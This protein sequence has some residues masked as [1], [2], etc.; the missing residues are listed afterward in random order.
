MSN[1]INSVE[2]SPPVPGEVVNTSCGPIQGKRE[3]GIHTFLGIPFAAPPLGDLRWKPPQPAS[4]WTETRECFEFGPACP[5]RESKFIKT[6]EKDEDC[7][8]LNVWTP[9]PDP[10]AKLPVMF[11]LQGGNFQTGSAALRLYNGKNMA[12]SGAVMVTINYRVGPLGFLAHPELSE[13]SAE[14]VSGNYGLLDQVAALEWVRDN[15]EAFGGDPSLVTIFGFSSGAN[16]VCN[17]M[18]MEE[19]FSLYSRAI[20]QSGPLWSHIGIPGLPSICLE[21][22]KGEEIGTKFQHSLGFD[23]AKNVIGKMREIEP[24]DLLKVAGSDGVF[25]TDGLEF[26]PIADGHHMRLHPMALFHRQKQADVPLII[27]SNL[28][29]ANLFLHDAKFSKL[30]YEMMVRMVT[31][32]HAEKVFELFPFESDKQAGENFAKIMAIGEFATPARFVARSM[33]QKSSEPFLYQFTGHRKDHPL[34]ACHGAE[35]AYVLG[36]LSPRKCDETDFELSRQIMGYWLNFART[37]NPN[38]GGLPEWPV[39]NTEDDPYMIL[40]K[41]LSTRNGVWRELC[42]IAEIIYSPIYL[43]E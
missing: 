24:G 39:Y 9:N 38:G 43:E 18:V 19:A 7:L 33:E 1:G 25:I 13:E 30:Q 3:D 34:K 17:L 11:W 4:P 12:K 21:R 41:P 10:T 28:H 32:P 22:E 15:I 14:G 23:G 29:E 6:G 16:C 20:I 31:G 5:Q 27:G 35:V 42:D 8:Y 26:C 37:G 40:G 36:N 2:E